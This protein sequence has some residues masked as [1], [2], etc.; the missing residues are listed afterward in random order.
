VQ[1]SFSGF[2]SPVDNPPIL[3]VVKAGGTVPVK[4]LL[5][6]A[7]GKNSTALAAV[8]AIGSNAIRCPTATSDP[9]ADNVSPG[10]AGLRYDSQYV[11][12]WPTVAKWAGTCRQFYA[13]MADGTKKVANFQF[14]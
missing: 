2:R 4:W 8:F 10:L 7:S 13:M 14:K 12:N 9:D 1:Y 3:N 11:Y 5:S 6:D